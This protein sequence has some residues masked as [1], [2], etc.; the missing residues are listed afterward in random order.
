MSGIA[1]ETFPHGR[2]VALSPSTRRL[3]APNAGPFT[4]AGTNTYIVGSGHVA[5]VD[6]GPAIPSHIDALLAAIA[7]ETV[8]HILLTHTHRDHSAAAPELRAA[9]GAPILSGGP[10]RPARPLAAGEA[11]PLDEANDLDHVPD[12]AL[13]DGE[14]VEVGGWRLQA[15]T[16]PGHTA[17]HIVFAVLGSVLAFSGDHVMGWSTTI[18]AP[19]DGAMGDYMASLD[20]LMARPERRF[21]PGHGPLV[22]DAVGRLA[23]LKRHRLM[24]EAAILDRLRRGDRAIPEMVAAIYQDV[25]RSLHGAAALSVLAHLEDLVLRGRVATDGEPRLSGRYA[26]A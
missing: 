6:P 5:I 16:T 17:N 23:Y 13:A 2:A 7:G 25:D 10:H 9:T 8:T 3:T 14:V 15:L 22:E 1:T 11:N 18:I 4:H 19:P 26:L 24:R 21:L 20:K 12:H